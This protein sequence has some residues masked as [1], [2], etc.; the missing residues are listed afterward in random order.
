MID[1]IPNRPRNIFTK[2]TLS[3]DDY[4]GD[5]TIIYRGLIINDMGILV[6]LTNDGWLMI[7]LGDYT[8][9]YMGDY[10]NPMGDSL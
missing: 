1:G 10:S 4:D 8:T 9:Q 2:R 3:V 7:S 5:L 6:Y